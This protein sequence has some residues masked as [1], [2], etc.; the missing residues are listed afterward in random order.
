M[1]LCDILTSFLSSK[2]DLV[3]SQRRIHDRRS[4]P[5]RNHSWFPWECRLCVEKHVLKTL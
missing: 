2:E 4:G 1:K 5:G 3:C